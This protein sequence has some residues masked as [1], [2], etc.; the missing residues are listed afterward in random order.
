MLISHGYLQSLGLPAGTITNVVKGNNGRYWFLYDNLDLYLYSDTGKKANF[1][2]QN[3]SF[4]SSGKNF[5]HK[6]NK[7]WEIM[8]GVIRMDFYS[9]MI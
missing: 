2:R 7:R 1:S 6:R 3:P 5:F 4:N 8:D 9:S